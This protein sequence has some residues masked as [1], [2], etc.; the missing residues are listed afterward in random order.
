MT[1]PPAIDLAAP[2]EIDE[3]AHA[4]SELKTKWAASTPDERDLLWM[5]AHVASEQLWT[6]MFN[7]K[8]QGHG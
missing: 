5:N 1:A 3:Y 2:P 6:R 7:E 4:V 8:E